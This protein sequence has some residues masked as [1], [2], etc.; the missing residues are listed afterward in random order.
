MEARIVPEVE[1]P[2]ILAESKDNFHLLNVYCTTKFLLDGCFEGSKITIYEVVEGKDKLYTFVMEFLGGESLHM[3]LQSSSN[4][5]DFLKRATHTTLSTIQPILQKYESFLCSSLAEPI[6]KALI[7]YSDEVKSHPYMPMN[8]TAL[9]FYATPQQQ[10]K[11]KQA[12]LTLPEEFE[13]FELKR[14]DAQAIADEV[15]FFKSPKEVEIIASKIEHLPAVGIRHKETGELACYEIN[16]GTGHLS[17]LHTREKFRRLGLAS[18]IEQKLSLENME[19]HNILPMKAVVD[20][21][22][23]VIAMSKNSYL[24]T[25]IPDHEGNDGLYRWICRSK[26]PRDQV[27]FYEN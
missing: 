13:Y 27:I 11:L 10:N 24:W 12:D 23:R 15:I 5:L 17:S 2:R 26:T 6:A 1:Y 9:M 22:P 25:T 14:K 4:Q 19:K 18:K 21:R 16:D 20:S 7:E 8:V 3:I